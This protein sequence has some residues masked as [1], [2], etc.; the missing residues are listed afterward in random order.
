M[1]YDLLLQIRLSEF[2]GNPL[3]NNNITAVIEKVTT[4][5]GLVCRLIEPKV[6]E[7]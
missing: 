6:G 1:N 5:G 3:K 4:T 7:S 2:N